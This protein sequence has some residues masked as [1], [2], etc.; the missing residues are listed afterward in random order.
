MLVRPPLKR[1]KQQ[2]HN[3]FEPSLCY[4]KDSATNVDNIK[5]KKKKKEKEKM[6]GDMV[7]LY[8]QLKGKLID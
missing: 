4:W 3:D 1:I 8:Q 6:V 7:S 5:F 2:D